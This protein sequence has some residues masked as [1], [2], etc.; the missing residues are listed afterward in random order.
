MIVDAHTDLLLEV[1]FRTHRRGEANPFGEQWLPLLEQGRVA[2]QVCPAYADLAFLPE[3]ALRE[4]LSQVRVFN[5]AVRQNPDRV[6]AVRR[7]ADLDRVERGGVIGLLLSVEGAEALGYDPWMAEIMWDLGVRMMS[8]TWNRRNPFADGAAET[9]GA[10]LS[11]LG[12]QLVDLCAELGMILD[13]AHASERAFW[14]VLDR[15]DRGLVV[16]SHA[17][18]RAIHDHPRNLSDRQL[19]GLAERGGV[20]GIMHHPLAIDPS[21][22]SLDRVVDH[23]DH[24]AE[25]MGIEHV[26]LGADFTRQV[27]RALGWEEPPDALLPAGMRADAAI[28]DLAGPEDYPNLVTAL[29]RRGYEAERLSAV[30][31]GNLLRA[32]RSALPS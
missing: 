32:F 9:D 5:R 21:D 25:V 8:L 3:G 31:G 24:A 7:Q 28:T 29:E 27:V 19:R 14:E 1:A 2:L 13:L 4:V 12:K 10:G 22:P 18:C 17:A 26:G 20:L 11:E 23:I 16:V 30:L 15:V 6:L